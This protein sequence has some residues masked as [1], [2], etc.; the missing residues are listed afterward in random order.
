VVKYGRK[1]SLFWCNCFLGNP[2]STLFPSKA[3]SKKSKIHNPKSAI[4]NFQIKNQ[5]DNQIT[6]LAFKKT[7]ILFIA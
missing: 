7:T 1:W 3:T 2:K 4:Q 6:R 5:P